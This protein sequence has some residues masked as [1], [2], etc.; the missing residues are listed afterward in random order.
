[1]VGHGEKTHLAACFLQLQSRHESVNNKRPVSYPFIS[2]FPL[3]NWSL[4]LAVSEN[5]AYP[6]W[7]NFHET[8]RCFI[9][10]YKHFWSIESLWFS[11]LKES[12]RSC[13]LILM[14]LRVWGWRISGRC[15][16]QSCPGI[17]L[18]SRRCGAADRPRGWRP[19]NWRSALHPM[20][21]EEPPLRLS[22]AFCRSFF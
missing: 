19:E 8:K 15:G 4:C 5:G 3:L 12:S 10:M 20:W 7:L 11:L 16:L 21:R 6:L 17:R 13:S 9:N 22:G 14:R 18:W 1:M 2:N